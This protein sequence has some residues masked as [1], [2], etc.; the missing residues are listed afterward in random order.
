MALR[1]S[2]TIGHLKAACFFTLALAA[3]CSSA[4]PPQGQEST[5]SVRSAYSCNA[6]N[7]ICYAGGPLMTGA[8]HIYF[9]WYG[10]WASAEQDVAV[11]FAANVGSSSWWSIVQSYSDSQGV[12]V[13]TVTYT[14]STSV[15]ASPPS[16]DYVAVVT[17][18]ITSG[19]LP[20]DAQGLYV[21]MGASGTNFGDFAGI[22]GNTNVSGTDVKFAAINPFASNGGV[23]FGSV[24]DCQ[25]NTLS[26]ELGEAATDADPWSGWST[27]QPGW[28]GVSGE[29]GDLCESGVGQT[30]ELWNGASAN[31][32][33]YDHDYL[34][35]AIWV[36]GG[37]GYCA[38]ARWPDEGKACSGGGD[39]PTTQ[40]CQA[41]TCAMPSC[42]DGARDG[43]EGDVD[44]GGS[45][46]AKCA[47][48][49]ACHST[50]D[51]L[52]SPFTHGPQLGKMCLYG[53][54]GGSCSDGVKDGDETDVDCGGS[55][56]LCANGAACLRDVD[57]SSASCAFGL[58]VAQSCSNGVTDTRNGETDV[59][60]GGTHCA[61]CANLK[62]CKTNSDCQSGTCGVGVLVCEAST[63]IDGVKDG[64]ESG[65]DCGGGSCSP[66]GVGGGCRVYRDC[67]G[68]GACVAGTCNAPTCSD[69]IT[70]GNEPSTD[71]GG[72]S[73]PTCPAGRLCKVNADCQSNYCIV[74]GALPGCQA[75]S[76]TD[77]VKDG[78]EVDV[79]CGG[80]A[81]PACA[82]LKQC[83]SNGDC[84]SG[85]CSGGL[86][87]ATSC[88]NDVKDGS[89]TGIDCGGGV[90]AQCALGGGCVSATDCSGGAACILG[91]CATPTCSDNV[92]DGRE[93][94]IDC[95]GGV[96]PACGASRGCSVGKDCASGTCTASTCAQ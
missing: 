72:G 29:M 6:P 53:V 54:C 93:T 41:G 79:D 51:C 26:H 70:N 76:C 88:T 84:Q 43:D 3:G 50:A 19:A 16:S 66:C 48:G 89:E 4:A 38:T 58:C 64:T 10:T 90:C 21:V 96:C 60:C 1:A 18:A 57:C 5:G 17:N 86:C 31:A 2:S 69:G 55:C 67:V 73:C 68:R 85:F 12:S 62:R 40:R 11:A 65:V 87:V 81:C 75:A 24:I 82:N 13:G 7:E 37:G 32:H 83:A 20:L 52:G 42:T 8:I 27:D 94:D 45:C 95:G 78:D 35:Q 44:C 77:G 46:A 15:S 92:R 91:S 23:D 14:S 61:A 63:C 47:R 22:H 9:I 49:Q 71:C 28:S 59:D 74:G 56:S 25:V 36:N 39:C 80:T 30:Y 34:L 33:F